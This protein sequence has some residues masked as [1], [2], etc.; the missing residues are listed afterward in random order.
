MIKLISFLNIFVVLFYIMIVLFVFI[1][2]NLSLWCLFIYVLSEILENF[3]EFIFINVRL[4][5]KGSLLVK[6]V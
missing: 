6:I 2:L 1:I 4:K 5:G 3:I